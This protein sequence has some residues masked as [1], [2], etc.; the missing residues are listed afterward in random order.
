VKPKGLTVAEVAQ[1]L[2]VSQETVRRWVRS[3]GLVHTRDLI[4][5]GAPIY[6]TREDLDDYLVKRNAR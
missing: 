5:R 4:H 2:D 6:I 3:D 1:L